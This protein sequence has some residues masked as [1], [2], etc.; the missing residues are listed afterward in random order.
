MENNKK[1]ARFLGYEYYPRIENQPYIEAGWKN[2]EHSCL[3]G[4]GYLCRTHKQL[5]FDK[6][7]NR[8]MCVVNKIESLD[9]S[10]YF[11][12]WEDV[13]NGLVNNFES[14]TV[15]IYEN[16]CDIYVNLTLD[17]QLYISDFKRGYSS[18]IEATYNSCIQFVDYYNNLIKVQ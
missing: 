9:L 13:E 3:K 18:K 5:R 14:V 4:T 12:S 7:W 15:E 17:P 11:Y 16:K 6:D 8:L 1:L 10:E 2:Y